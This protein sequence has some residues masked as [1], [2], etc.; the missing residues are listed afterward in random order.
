MKL[1]S[2]RNEHKKND[3]NKKIDRTS[4]TTQNPI[5]NIQKLLWEMRLICVCVSVS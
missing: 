1:N 4:C 3:N 2:I 5:E